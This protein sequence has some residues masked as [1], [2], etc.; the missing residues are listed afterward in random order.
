[1]CFLL[2]LASLLSGLGGLSTLALRLLDGLDD[3]D[4]DGLTHVPD[5]ETTERGEL[6]EGLNAHGLLGKHL[7]DGGISRLDGLGALLKGLSGTTVDLLDELGELAGDVCGVAIEDWGVTGGDLAGV[8]E[9]DDLGVE[10]SGLLGGG[11]LGVGGDE[12]TT[13]LLDGDVLDVEADVVTWEGLGELL[14]VHLDGLDLS[15]ELAGG[16]GHNH[17][18]LED[19]SLHTADGDSA[20]T[21]DLVHVLE[22]QTEGLVGGTCGGL[23]GVEGIDEGLAG[24]LAALALDFPTLEPGH[25]GGGL[26]HV[27]TVPAGDG[28][29]GDGL[30][31]VADLLDV[32]GDLLLDLVEALLRVL[33]GV[34]LVDGD[35]ELLD[36]EGVG[37]QGVLTGLTVLGDTGLE[38]SSAGGNDEDGAIGLGGS[39]DHVLDEVTVARGVND[40]DVELGG[41]ELPEG[42][43]DG[44]ATL[45]LGLQLVKNPGVLEGTLAHVGGILL[46]LLNG[47]L[48]NTAELVDKVTGGGGLAGVDVSNDDDVDVSLFLSHCEEFCSFEKKRKRS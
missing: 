3:S 30:G 21:A 1:V 10:G 7:D 11:V 17:V 22:G 40:G 28:H 16:E 13:E 46:E 43:V 19:S 31:D 23:D 20:D 39:G 9:D 26:E 2:L 8:V 15:G 35:D 36:S 14:V 12:A 48:V 18:G 5:G 47:T 4:G 37:E 27:V 29:E 38:L 45:T 33:A 34:H 6:L 32:S 44:D 41:L 24:G 25:V 42:D